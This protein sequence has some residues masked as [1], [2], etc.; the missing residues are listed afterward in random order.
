MNGD[1]STP[2]WYYSKAGVP[3]GPQVGP[4]PW[5]QLQSLAQTGTLSP[6]DLVWNPQLPQWTPAVQ[7]QGLFPA[8]AFPGTQP[9]YAPAPQPGAQW[10]G[11]QP[12]GAYGPYPGQPAAHSAPRH[13]PWLAWAIPVTVLVL[14]GL[15]LGLFFGLRGHDDNGTTAS[16]RTTTTRPATVTTLPGTVTTTSGA[17][18]STTATATG[19]A[20]TRENPIPL[21]QE[22][23]MGDW[24]VKISK[25][26]VDATQAI[27]AVNS[28]GDTPDAGSQYVLVNIE[29]TNTGSAS[30]DYYYDADWTFVASGGDTF[31]PSSVV[32]PDDLTDVGDTPP[33][34]TASGDVVFMVD[35]N[36]VSDGV[37]MIENL[38][39]SAEAAVYFATTAVTTTTAAGVTAT[40]SALPTYSEVVSTY[41]PGSELIKTEA[42][43]LSGD[44][45]GLQLGNVV[46]LAMVNGQ[47]VYK[48]FG[49]KLTVRATITLEGKTYQPGAKLTVDKNLHW[50][51]VSSWG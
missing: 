6:A 33:G 27:I 46:D 16:I 22:V 24:K 30:A 28:P 32:A 37:V 35:S 17:S 11:A 51:E 5:E 21:G 38:V 7:I 44:D 45:D 10:P 18:T 31:T 9:P 43:I 12:G 4:F 39:D 1:P 2:S 13:V 50:I 49:T 20:G 26:T 14:A 29:A 19:A 40:T 8:A 25:V 23:Q 48:S 47:F 36:Q 42:D 3:G 41:P 34:G 15:G